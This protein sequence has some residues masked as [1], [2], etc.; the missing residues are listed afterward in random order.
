MA[1]L[2]MGPPCQN[3]Y[4]FF[5]YLCSNTYPRQT[6]ANSGKK[7]YMELVSFDTNAIMHSEHIYHSISLCGS[8]INQI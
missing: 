5:F 2:G 7:I 3:F 6:F 1:A 8:Y 4:F